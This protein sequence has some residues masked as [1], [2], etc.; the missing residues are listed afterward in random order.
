[1]TKLLRVTRRKKKR[2]KENLEDPTSGLSSWPKNSL[3]KREKHTPPL[4]LVPPVLR[5]ERVP[6]SSFFLAHCLVVVLWG[7]VKGSS[8]VSKPFL[9]PFFILLFSTHYSSHLILSLHFDGYV[10]GSAQGFN[11]SH[12]HFFASLCHQEVREE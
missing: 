2:K 10:L 9:V 8:C 7:K 1:M 3:H 5:R 6:S 4:L 12:T 11:P